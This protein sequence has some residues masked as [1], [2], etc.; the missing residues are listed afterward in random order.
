MTKHTSRFCGTNKQLHRMGAR[1]DPFC[2]HK[3]C[4]DSHE[5]KDTLHVLT[6]PDTD[7]TE[8][9]TECIAEL[10]K[11]MKEA[12]TPGPLIMLVRRYL[13]GRAEV[14]MSSLAPR[15]SAILKGTL[16][17]RKTR[18]D[19]KTSPAGDSAS[20]LAPSSR[21]TTGN[22][23]QDNVHVLGAEGLHNSSCSSHMDCGWLGM[24]WL[25]TGMR[26]GSRQ[27]KPGN[28]KRH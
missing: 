5:I 1:K 7:R 11:W 21:H 9:F 10:C 28:W 27:R 19:G 14:T 2:P 16:A 13:E 12:K 22:T 4:R 17:R 3:G 20:L 18:S 26:M 23:T 8:V 6:C 24:K 15:N 25:T